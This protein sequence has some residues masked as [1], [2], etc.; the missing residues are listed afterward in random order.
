[1]AVMDQ[2]GSAPQQSISGAPTDAILRPM[3]NLTSSPSAPPA[4]TAAAAAVQV[5]GS[6]P[7]QQTGPALPPANG[8]NAVLDAILGRGP[9]PVHPPGPVRRFALL[10]PVGPRYQPES[11]EPG[12]KPWD[13]TLAFQDL[14]FCQSSWEPLTQCT[15]TLP[16]RSLREVAT[17]LQAA[18]TTPPPRS[19]LNER[20]LCLFGVEAAHGPAPEDVVVHDHVLGSGGFGTV[21]W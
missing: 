16:P 4:A 9:F 21:H 20:L 18:V 7:Q 3:P 13:A 14:P 2:P 1:M 5:P 8:A 15:L 17:H 12:Y 6:A 10:Q 11:V 19:S